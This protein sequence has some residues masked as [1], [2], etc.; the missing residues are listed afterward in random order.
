SPGASQ[1]PSSTRP[2]SPGAAEGKG[3]PLTA[4]SYECVAEDL[5]FLTSDRQGS[6]HLLQSAFGCEGGCGNQEGPEL[7]AYVSGSTKSLTAQQCLIP[8]NLPVPKCEA[9]HVLTQRL[10]VCRKR[11]SP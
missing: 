3:L 2:A 6:C 9:Q 7:P 8:N 5:G 1:T 10:C 4:G 11:G